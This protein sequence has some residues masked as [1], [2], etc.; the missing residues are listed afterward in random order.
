MNEY[1]RPFSC[2]DLK[3][4]FYIALAGETYPDRLYHIVRPE[5]QVSVI[6]Y[7]TEGEGYV[8]IDGKS[9]H[10]SK[11][12]IYFL[13]QGQTH[14]YYA[15]RDN[16]FTKIWLNI[17]GS[18]CEHLASVYGLSGKYFFDGKGLKP[19]FE[20]ILNIIHSDMPD[21]E[22][23]CA[24]QGIFVEIISNLCVA[25]ARLGHSEEA[26]K[27]KGYLDANIGKL[28]SL[29]ELSEIIFRSPDYCQKLFSREYHITPYAYQLEQKMKTAKSLLANTNMP[30][31]EIAEKLGYSDIHYFSN[32]FQKKCGCRP[33]AYRKNI[34]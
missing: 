33:S 16:P 13:P 18:F 9:H 24:L 15:D 3:L 28:I 30:L 23:Q 4:P 32:L 12:T 19:N 31:G 14:D 25:D 17:S 34:I 27:L 21:Q 10:V 6:E 29:K 22:M 8:I 1:L 5:S 11:D 7:I 20:K 26:L 2:F